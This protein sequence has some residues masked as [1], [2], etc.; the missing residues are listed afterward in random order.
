MGAGAG[1]AGIRGLGGCIDFCSSAPPRGAVGT[2]VLTG[3]NVCRGAIPPFLLPGPRSPGAGVVGI[4]R[5]GVEE[6]G[7]PGKAADWSFMVGVA[8]SHVGPGHAQLT[9]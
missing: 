4:G 3:A 5:D 6:T 8:A 2:A 9:G 7:D 1:A